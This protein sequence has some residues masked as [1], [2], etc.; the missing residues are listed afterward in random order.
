MSRRGVFC[1]VMPRLFATCRVNCR[2]QYPVKLLE[3]LDPA[4]NRV[5]VNEVL[6]AY[7]RI[8]GDAVEVPL[9]ARPP[10]PIDA[11]QALNLSAGVSNSRVL[12]GRSFS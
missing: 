8:D 11:T 6:L 12:R 3:L 7:L 1:R 5:L 10:Q 4:F 9:F 2:A